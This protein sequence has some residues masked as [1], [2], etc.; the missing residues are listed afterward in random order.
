MQAGSLVVCIDDYFEAYA[1]DHLENFPEK[2]AYYIIREVLEC[3]DFPD[4]GELGVLLEE[5]QNTQ[6]WLRSKLSGK[7]YFIEPGFFMRR[8]REVQPPMEVGQLVEEVVRIAK[9]AMVS[10]L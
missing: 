4:N 7:E 2:G 3:E 10:E 6:R 5:V 1:Y 8:F 9:Y